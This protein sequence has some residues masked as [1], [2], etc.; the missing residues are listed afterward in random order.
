[1]ILAR[2]IIDS[3]PYKSG[4]CARL[5]AHFLDEAGIG[6]RSGAGKIGD[7]GQHGDG[8]TFQVTHVVTPIRTVATFN[9]KIQKAVE[10]KPVHNLRTYD[11]HAI[12]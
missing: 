11:V 12:P 10:L 7:A 9:R 3:H 1:M 8:Y 5:Q 6:L 2:R 4:D